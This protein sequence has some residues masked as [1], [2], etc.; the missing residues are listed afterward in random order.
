MDVPAIASTT[1]NEK[2]VSSLAASSSLESRIAALFNINLASSSSM[3]TTSG[4]S[5]S[6]PLISTQHHLP[7]E[8]AQFTCPVTST[9]QQSPLQQPSSTV[10]VN[11]IPTNTTTPT[12]PC[13]SSLSPSSNQVNLLL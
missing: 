13:S 4:A 1:T 7:V 9:S 11:T 6:Q 5:A 3:P 2:A 8:V 12:Q 10:F